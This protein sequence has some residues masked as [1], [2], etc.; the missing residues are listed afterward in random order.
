MVFSHRREQPISRYESEQESRKE[1]RI[2]RNFNAKENL[3]M[4]FAICHE[5]FTDWDWERQ[6]RFIAETGYT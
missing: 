4:K 5:M 1:P 2:A 6:C 3:L